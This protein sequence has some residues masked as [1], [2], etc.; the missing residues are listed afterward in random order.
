[1][2]R[3]LARFRPAIVM[4]LNRPALAALGGTVDDVWSLL[5]G[6]SYRIRAFEAWDARDPA[7]VATLNE[8]KTR[9]PDD[10]LIDIL[11]VPPSART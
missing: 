1:M 7:P 4:E 6:L 5:T 10:T 11:A 9:C 3:T 2:M 8:L